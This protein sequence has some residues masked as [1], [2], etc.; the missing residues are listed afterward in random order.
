[1]SDLHQSPDLSSG[2]IIFFFV[3]GGEQ[4]PF[5]GAKVQKLAKNGGEAEARMGENA[6]MLPL[7]AATAWS[8]S[9]LILIFIRR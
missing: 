2:T 6:P 4:N 1:M 3:G 7:G 8:P 5:G 9:D